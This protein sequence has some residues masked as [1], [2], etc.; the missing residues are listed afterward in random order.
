MAT[1]QDPNLSAYRPEIFSSLLSQYATIPVA[2]AP[3]TTSYQLPATSYKLQAT[4]GQPDL[5]RN[6]LQSA[7]GRPFKTARGSRS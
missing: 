6:S 2:A 1:H 3:L 7:T 5:T 4:S